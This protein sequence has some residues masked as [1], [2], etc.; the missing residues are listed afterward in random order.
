[1]LLT[2]ETK[3]AEPGVSSSAT[4][5]RARLCGVVAG[6]RDA[7]LLGWVALGRPPDLN[8]CG[9]EQPAYQ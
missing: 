3:V 1:M 6:G 4:C 8:V 7:E 5:D 9:E 2:K